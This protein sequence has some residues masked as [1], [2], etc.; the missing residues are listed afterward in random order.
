MSLLACLIRCEIRLNLI[1]INTLPCAKL[2]KVKHHSLLDGSEIVQAIEKL[3]LVVSCLHMPQ[4]VVG[5]YQMLRQILET[6]V[7]QARDTLGIGCVLTHFTLDCRQEMN[8]KVHCN[9]VN[10]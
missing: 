7:S 6:H 1:S 3:D 5:V 10:L 2:L 8:F 9:T 4:A